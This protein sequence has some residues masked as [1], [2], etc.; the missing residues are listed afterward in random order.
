MEKGHFIAIIS[1]IRFNYGLNK[2]NNLL[3]LFLVL[4]KAF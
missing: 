1:L 4:N 2:N 3:L